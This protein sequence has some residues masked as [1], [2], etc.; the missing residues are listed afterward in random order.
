[1]QNNGFFP[2][3]SDLVPMN[4]AALAPYPAGPVNPAAGRQVSKEALSDQCRA[5]LAYTAMENSLTLSAIEAYCRQTAP[6]GEHRYKLIAD[7]YAMA[8]AARI[9]RW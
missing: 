6:L 1:M 8:A 7:A 4:P 9:A 2:V 3:R 5:L